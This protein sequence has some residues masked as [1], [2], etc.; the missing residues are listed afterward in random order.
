[1]SERQISDAQALDAIQHILR[2]P[3]WDVA[4]LEDIS[5]LIEA[6][7]RDL[8]DNPDGVATWSRH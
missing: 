3:E 5:D 7:G 8:D 1:M 2:D 4:M 6:T